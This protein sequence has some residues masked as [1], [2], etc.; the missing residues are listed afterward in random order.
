VLVEQSWGL[1]ID[2]K[3]QFFYDTYDALVDLLAATEEIVQNA[4]VSGAIFDEMKE[5]LGE[6]T[7]HG[8]VLAA[9]IFDR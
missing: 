6:S 7:M 1:S 3:K 9:Q 5:I 4:G 2:V 8:D